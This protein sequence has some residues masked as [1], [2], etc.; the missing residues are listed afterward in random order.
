[1][2]NSTSQLP[3]TTKQSI[4]SHRNK[5]YHTA[6]FLSLII[7]A[8]SCS[9]VLA[10]NILSTPLIEEFIEKKITTEEEMKKKSSFLDY[11]IN[12]D[13]L[14]PFELNSNMTR[15]VFAM[16]HENEQGTQPG[17]SAGAEAAQPQ[18]VLQIQPPLINHEYIVA[19]VN[20]LNTWLDQT[21]INTLL[22]YIPSI[23]NEGLTIAKMLTQ[24]I[25]ALNITV[26]EDQVRLIT[27]LNTIE[28]TVSPIDLDKPHQ[29]QGLAILILSYYAAIRSNGA[30]SQATHFFFQTFLNHASSLSGIARILDKKADLLGTNKPILTLK[31]LKKNVAK[32]IPVS[33]DIQFWREMSYIHL[34]Q[35]NNNPLFIE[36]PEI[37]ID[38]M[39]EAAI[40][41]LT[42]SDN[43]IG[44]PLYQ[45]YIQSE[46][47]MLSV[48]QQH[49]ENNPEI[50]ASSNQFANLVESVSMILDPFTIQLATIHVEN[51]SSYFSAS[52]WDDTIISSEGKEKKKIKEK[53][54]F[55]IF[56][57]LLT[58]AK[59]NPGNESPKIFQELLLSLKNYIEQRVQRTFFDRNELITIMLTLWT[60]FSDLLTQS[61]TTLLL[62]ESLTEVEDYLHTHGIEQ[63]ERKRKYLKDRIKHLKDFSIWLN[64][65]YRAFMNAYQRSS[66]SIRRTDS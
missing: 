44:M 65:N 10:E 6:A 3:E 51:M 21:T 50:V 62:L 28:D 35:M 40:T 29:A 55:K 39:L 4:F 37:A 22:D 13:R 60:G 7:M 52:Y 23:S 9:K 19:T 63:K 38:P 26:N 41:F 66:Q 59:N 30:N 20:G 24:L 11:L 34:L 43:N 8:C 64:S 32:C 1:M 27:I 48:M 61:E 14:P 25:H 15:A 17:T 58:D 57:K 54:L 53:K 2:S 5:A 33:S 42:Y 47:R 36:E 45:R 31:T 56:K 18:A 49:G 46:I 16:N 12:I